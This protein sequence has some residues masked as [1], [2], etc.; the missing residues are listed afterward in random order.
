M[1]SIL[2]LAYIIYVAVMTIVLAW[3][4]EEGLSRNNQLAF[5]F[6][7]F[8]YVTTM[9]YLIL[10]S[11]GYYA[12]A[13]SLSIILL[14]IPIVLRN[15][16][17]YKS[18]IISFLIV[19]E[20]IMSLLYYVILRG[21]GH[22]IIALDVYGTDIPTV[23]ITSSLQIPI[24]LIELAN[25][26]MF[27][28]MIFPEIAYFS[29]KVKNFYPLVISA[30]AL[31][32]PNI[33]SEMTHSILPLPYDPFREASILVTILSFSLTLFM[34]YNLLKGKIMDSHYLIFIGIN[35]VL[36]LTSLYYSIT[37]NEIP[38]GL[39]TLIAVGISFVI[40]SKSFNKLGNNFLVILPISVIPQIL[41]SISVCEFYNVI[42]LSYTVA[43]GVT[44]PFLAAMFY[45]KKIAKILR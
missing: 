1:I 13:A 43:L 34:T 29:Y 10:F 8:S 14:T 28:I 16:G 19:N 15:L 45:V 35:S 39:A 7:V 17:F 40:P 44:L 4:V 32:G 18:S 20:I 25:S 36:S 27:F 30:L 9:M 23:A 6:M 12:I 24:A 3:S 41:W 5:L 22:A 31:A 42:Y 33:A 11:P 38:Y 2:I 26:F 21:F 37:I